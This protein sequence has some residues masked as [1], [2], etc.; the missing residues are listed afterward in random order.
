MKVRLTRKLAECLD[1]VDVSDRQVGDVLDLTRR[2]AELLVA[3]QWAVP[4]RRS[5]TGTPPPIERRQTDDPE[6]FAASALDTRPPR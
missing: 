2:E 5:G 3:E 4:E 6:W 1:G